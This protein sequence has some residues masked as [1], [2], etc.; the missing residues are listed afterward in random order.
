MVAVRVEFFRRRK[1][2]LERLEIFRDVRIE[3][4]GLDTRK[5]F[6]SYSLLW[7][8]RWLSN[9]ESTFK[10]S[11]GLD[12]IMEMALICRASSVISFNLGVHSRVSRT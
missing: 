8:L 4:K 12:E 7:K 9:N 10:I 3:E 5:S 6:S 1:E 11:Q 2:Y